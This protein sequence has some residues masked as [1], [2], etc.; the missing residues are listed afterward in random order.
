MDIASEG[1]LTLELFERQ[2]GTDE[3]VMRCAPGSESICGLI[4]TLICGLQLALQLE[5]IVRMAAGRPLCVAL[6]GGLLSLSANC[7]LLWANMMEDNGSAAAE[8]L[9][10]RLLDPAVVAPSFGAP[11]AAACEAVGLVAAHKF[12]ETISAEAMPL[13]ALPPPSHPS[14]L[15]LL[16]FLPPRPAL[17]ALPRAGFDPDGAAPARD[18]RDRTAGAAIAISRSSRQ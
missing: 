2:S 13:P 10:V 18:C 12:K 11:V 8:P 1:S 9:Q 16:S 15:S 6:Q 14:H 5:Q 17:T 7:R 3:Q 4:C